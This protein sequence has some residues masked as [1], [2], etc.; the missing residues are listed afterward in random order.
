MRYI[1]L[2]LFSSL[3]FSCKPDDSFSTTPFDFNKPD[4]SPAIPN[5]SENPLT[6]EGVALGKKLFYDKRLSGDNTMSC[7]GC[8]KQEQA[9]ATNLRVEKG[10]DNIEGTRNSMPLFNLIWNDKDFF[11]DGR[12]KTLEEQVL[13]PVEDPIEMHEEWSNAIEEIKADNTYPKLFKNAF[14]VEKKN[15]SKFEAAKALSQFLRSIVSFNSKYDKYKRNEL[16][17]TADELAGLTMFRIEGPIGGVPQG[18]ADC[19]HCHGEPLFTDYLFRNNGL[20]S[21]NGITDL[22]L[23]QTTGNPVDRARFKTPTLRNLIYTAPYMHDGRFNTLEEVI[24]HYNTGG[25][26]S[27]TLDPDMKNS[28][29][30]LLLT[31]DEKKYLLAFLKTLSDPDFINNPEYKP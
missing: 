21:T 27:L 18:G 23:E 1:V 24:E 20:D 2:F 30:G 12:A 9:F 11:W 13:M 26:K 5:Y 15:I 14:N 7:N 28:E 22:G 31:P 3:I 8:H 4:G 17:L 10:I 29:F 25:H 6:K 19:F 16:D